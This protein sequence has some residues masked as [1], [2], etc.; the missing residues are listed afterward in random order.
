MGDWGYHRPAAATTTTGSVN[1]DSELEGSAAAASTT[2]LLGQGH[3]GANTNTNATGAGSAGGTVLYARRWYVCV[4][5]SFIAGL[6]GLGWNT[7]A[8]VATN[9]KAIYGP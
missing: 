6:Q 8:P 1:K 3:G 7:Y 9:I 2:P 4:L 5:F